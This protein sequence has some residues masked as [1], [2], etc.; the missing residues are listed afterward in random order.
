M[1][2]RSTVYRLDAAI[3]AELDGRIAA[4]GY[5]GYADH[6]A[7]L[8]EKGYAVSQAAIQRY[9]KRLKV[10]MDK[11]FMRTAGDRPEGSDD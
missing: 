5:G 8:A 4:A 6:A 11:E 7:W 3:R 10:L 9:S 1:P 2:L